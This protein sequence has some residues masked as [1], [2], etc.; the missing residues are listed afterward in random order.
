MQHFKSLYSNEDYH[1]TFSNI[2]TCLR[3]NDWQEI[4]D[5]THYLV[6]HMI[7]LFS[8]QQWSLKQSI[9]FMWS[10]LNKLDITPDYIT[11]HPD[12][13][14]EWSN[15]YKE[16]NVEIRSDSDCIW[17]DGNISGY[18]TE[19][20]KHGIEIGNIVNTLGKSIDIGFGLE[21]LEQVLNI[22]MIIPNK[23]EILE[24]TYKQ[25]IQDNIIIGHNK[26][27]YLL[28]K[29]IHECI[30]LGSNIQDNN[31]NNVRNNIK[32]NYQSYLKN[33]NKNKFKNK[34]PVFWLDTFGIDI[35]RLEEYKRI[36][37]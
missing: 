30:L 20:Y 7:G 19:F 4:G 8:F 11:I 34:E 12:K 21:R 33:V 23:I 24:Q 37:D 32:K 14:S 26:Q 16:Y 3:L 10:Y 31:F 5:G 6:F 36:I 1:N 29:I 9:D 35:S 28:K 17:G 2:Q 25:L 18:C 22:D 27:G 13:I 15:F